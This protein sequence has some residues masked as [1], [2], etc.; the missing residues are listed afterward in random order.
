[1]KYSPQTYAEALESVL[2]TTPAGEE[3]QVLKDFAAVIKKHGDQ[4][5]GEHIAH[6]FEALSVRKDGGRMVIL[7]T[8]RVLPDLELDKLKKSFGPKDR[9]TIKQ[10]PELVAGV[11]IIIDSERELDMTMAGK[12]E[13]MFR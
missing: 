4:G 13:K 8:A 1:M 2:A 6:A 12:L 3:D 5:S 9:L 11:R 10:N 7:E